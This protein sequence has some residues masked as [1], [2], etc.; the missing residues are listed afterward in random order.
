MHSNLDTTEREA[1]ASEFQA[2]RIEGTGVEP[3]RI[4][5]GTS[6]ILGQGITLN[7]AFRLVLT[8]PNRHAAVEAQIAKRVHRI[9]SNTDR[10]WIYR[11]TNPASRVEE[12]IVADQRNQ[13]RIQS[14]AES[15]TED[16]VA[17]ELDSV[18]WVMSAEEQGEGETGIDVDM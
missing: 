12:M 7:R 17:G 2:D 1:L 5:I 10:C 8:E 4:L 18:D 13:L 14:L 11:L 9:G 3:C 16:G 15:L 6:R